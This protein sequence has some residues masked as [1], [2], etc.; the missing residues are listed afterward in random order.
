MEILTFFKNRNIF[1]RFP[2][3][4]NS[5]KQKTLKHLM[6]HESELY[7]SLP[8]NVQFSK[9]ISFSIF[10]NRLSCS[11]PTNLIN[12]SNITNKINVMLLPSNLFKCSSANAFPIWME[13]SFFKTGSLYL[14]SYDIARGYIFG[15]V[16]ILFTIIFIIK[17]AQHIYRN[18][19]FPKP[20]EQ[21]SKSQP[22]IIDTPTI[23]HNNTEIKYSV[24][25]H[26]LK[27]QS[28][29]CDKY[30]CICFIL[31][32][33]VYYVNSQYFQCVTFIDQFSLSYY[34]LKSENGFKMTILCFLWMI[35]MIIISHNVYKIQIHQTH[36][37]RSSVRSRIAAVSIK[38]INF[39][40][41]LSMWLLYA[42]L[43]LF[44][45][46]FIIVYLIQ[47]SLPSDNIPLFN[48]WRVELLQ[49][50]MSFILTFANALIVPKLVTKS[51]ELMYNKH[52]D[53]SDTFISSYRPTFIF[54]LRSF[55]NILL[56]STLSI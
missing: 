36:Q 29:F 43:Y 54:I 42:I 45:I 13:S 24:K 28:Y 10:D 15:S 11:I 31:L 1:G 53:E 7:G 17:F 51:Y 33:I 8:H 9:L 48:E 56:P 23:F 2:I 20:Q 4:I 52:I 41:T 14:S 27:L 21:N 18:C 32:A 6:I 3:P 12:M 37:R 49:K 40:F 19:T 16:S 35:I 44:L 47:S 46:L 5:I 39:K 50:T 26:F 22:L 25:L 34:Y 38:Q 30:L 55:T